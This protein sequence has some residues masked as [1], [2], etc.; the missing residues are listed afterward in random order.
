MKTFLAESPLSC[1]EEWGTRRVCGLPSRR[2]PNLRK[3][4]SAKKVFFASPRFFPLPQGWLL[5]MTD[6]CR[7]CILNKNPHLRS[8]YKTFV[9]QLP[10]VC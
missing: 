7:I 2:V 8:V 3:G 10:G 9:R 4:D 6:I 5:A 1:F